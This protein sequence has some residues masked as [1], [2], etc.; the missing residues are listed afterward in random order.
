[1]GHFPVRNQLGLESFILMRAASRKV[2]M[3]PSEWF[4]IPMPPEKFSTSHTGIA[5]LCTRQGRD[6]I[7]LWTN[8][9]IHDI[10]CKSLDRYFLTMSVDST[11][12]KCTISNAFLFFWG[13]QILKIKN[14]LLIRFS[15]LSPSPWYI[16]HICPSLQRLRG[17]Y[18]AHA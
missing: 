12:S 5:F 8:K 14:F 16:K 6:S 4:D 11:L 13:N 10:S 15:C 2:N 7:S 1:M 3:W 9:F 17:R 18:E